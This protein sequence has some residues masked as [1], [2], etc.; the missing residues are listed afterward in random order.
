MCTTTHH[1]SAGIRTHTHTHVRQYTKFKGTLN[2]PEKFLRRAQ[3]NDSVSTERIGE[4]RIF[5]CRGVRGRGEWGKGGVALNRCT[6]DGTLKSAPQ[7][8]T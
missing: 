4:I 8:V 6:L 3:G 5:E 7:L 2:A 1:T